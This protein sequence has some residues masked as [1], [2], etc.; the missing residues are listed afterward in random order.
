MAS[1]HDFA[2]NILQHTGR[3]SVTH[4][5][6]LLYYCEAWNLVWDKE[7]LFPDRIEAWASGPMIPAIWS[8]RGEDFHRSGWPRGD[9]YALDLRER[10]AVATVLDHYG[11]FTP[12]QL[13]DLAMSEQPWKDAR[14]GIAPGMR[15]HTEITREALRVHFK[16][17]LEPDIC[18]RH[19]R[20]WPELGLEEIDR[21]EL[22][23]IYSF[24]NHDGPACGL[25]RWK[26]QHW[27]FDR[28]PD[29]HDF[30]F[31]V[32]LTPDEQ[33]Y[34]L[35]YG[36]EWARL[37]HNG[38]SWNPDGS[39]PEQ[40]LGVYGRREKNLTTMDDEAYKKFHQDNKRPEPGLDARVV[41]CFY[42]WH[43]PRTKAT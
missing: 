10:K 11:H 26:G 18:W 34:A 7:S 1:V 8:E 6:R 40:V 25:I 17:E 42:G 16:R 37:F 21:D 36:A 23:T 27:Y 20:N 13:S 41:A 15:G 43:S 35:H 24:E 9:P 39:Q 12:Q 29:T 19:L 22:D 33:E 30:Y 5:V 2:A 28:S 3:L 32:E 4:L 38:M 31:V 14:K